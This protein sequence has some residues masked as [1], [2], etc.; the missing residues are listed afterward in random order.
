MDIRQT[1]AAISTAMGEGGIAIVR[2]S[3]PDAFTAVGPLLSRAE[4]LMDMPTHT[5]AYTRFLDAPGGRQIDE[6]LLLK[7]AAPRSYTREHV[8]EIHCH[9]GSLVAGAVLRAIL[10]RGVRPAEPGEFTRRAFLNGRIDLAEAEAVMDLI[11]SQ[12]ERGARV[13]LDQLDGKLSGTIADLRESLL[14]LMGSLEVNLDYP[15]HDAE[16][17]ALAQAT[18]EIS[19]LR[20]QLSQLLNS[21]DEGRILRDGLSLVIAGRPNAGKSSLMNRLAGQERSIVTDV[22]GTTRDVVEIHANLRGLPIRLL[23]TAGLRESTDMVERIGVSRT[24]DA[25]ARADLI[26][27]VFDGADMPG[28]EDRRLVEKLRTSLV[29]VLYVL[30]KT[31]AAHP[32]AEA[33]LTALLPAAPLLLSALTGTGMTALLDAI[34]GVAVKQTGNGGNT[35]VLTNARHRQLLAGADERLAEAEQ[36]CRGGMTHDVLAFLLREAWDTLGLIIGDGS[37]DELLNSIF[38]RFCLGK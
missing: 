13:A 23:D 22:P 29:P 33:A 11:R 31:D 26:V 20:K 37:S 17:V 10:S 32:D 21:Y 34:E 15:E 9:G 5:V 1:I 36:A 38:S 25:M 16:E 2:V 24:L 4:S 6:V 27:A 30:N 19:K 8:V 7:M 3:G 12:T 18:S 14:L 28:E 35:V